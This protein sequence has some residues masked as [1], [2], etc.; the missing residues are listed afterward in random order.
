MS[1]RL[2]PGVLT[3]DH[4]P[5]SSIDQCCTR[6]N[7]RLKEQLSVQPPMFVYLYTS[8]LYDDKSGHSAFR[9][10]GRVR[11]LK[12]MIEDRRRTARAG[13]GLRKTTKPTD[14]AGVRRYRVRA[15]P[16][17]QGLTRAAR[18]TQAALISGP[19][20]PGRAHQ[21]PGVPRPRSSA[22]WAV[23]RPDDPDEG[24]LRSVEAQPPAHLVLVHDRVGV[25]ARDAGVVG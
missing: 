3:G 22:A 16:S 19:A 10:R 17:G 24:R 4:A 20:Y 5:F 12:P 13:S 7:S 2:R 6:R 1:V 23:P 9:P 18:R 15:Q 21:R 25:A 8:E 14:N 11:W